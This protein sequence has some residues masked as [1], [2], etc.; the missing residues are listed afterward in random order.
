MRFV[1]MPSPVGNLTLAAGA[2][3]LAAVYFERHA[4]GPDAH[5]RA[6]W[7][8][9]DGGNPES[10]ILARARDQL[11]AYFAGER[12]TFDLPLSPAG[13]PFQLRVWAELR[14]MAF[15]ATRSYGELALALGSPGA[16]R[17]VGAA[18]GRNPISIVVPCHRVV[19]ANGSLTGF[20]GGIER[21]R[22]LLAHEAA[23]L[24][25]RRNPAASI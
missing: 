5:E 4:H 16:A 6:A 18:N 3:G 9:D 24:G 10:G 25:A 19:G 2:H 14:R 7:L 17:A 11:T 22:W 21:K 8:P 1:I 12:T 20:G 15:G 13:T 23:V